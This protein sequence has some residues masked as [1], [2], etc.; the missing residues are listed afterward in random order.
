MIIN[1]LG[2]RMIYL[3]EIRSIVI[4]IK[5]ILLI[6]WSIIISYWLWEWIYW[7]VIIIYNIIYI[8]KWINLIFLVWILIYILE[9]IEWF[10][11]LLWCKIVRKIII[12]LII[13]IIN[14]YLLIIIINRSDHWIRIHINISL[15]VLKRIII[16]I[17]NFSSFN[18]LFS[19]LF[20]IFW[21]WMRYGRFSLSIHQFCIKHIPLYTIINGIQINY[22]TLYSNQVI[23]FIS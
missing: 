19:C 11:I 2:G 15:F 4:K 3:S 7:W 12:Y 8:L 22:L 1:I 9:W 21:R 18:L 17:W 14:I 13:I 20:S 5:A 23:I 16:I 10:L 6:N